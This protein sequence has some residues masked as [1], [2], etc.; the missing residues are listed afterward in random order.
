V[1]EQAAK[2][3]RSRLSSGAGSRAR[4]AL[5]CYRRDDASGFYLNAGTALELAMKARLLGYGVFAIAPSRV[6][7]GDWFAAVVRIVRDPDAAT[8]V[9]GSDALK[10]LQQ[11]EPSLHEAMQQQVQDTIARCNAVKHL[12]IGEPPG[13]DQLLSHAAAF[14]RANDVLLRVDPQKFWGEL[15]PLA[16]RLVDEELNAVGVRV[17]R[18]LLAARE[19][20]TLLGADAM[21]L[22]ADQEATAIADADDMAVSEWA[23]LNCPV[24]ESPARAFGETVDAGDAEGEFEDGAIEYRWIP[25]VVTLVKFFKCAVCGLRLAGSDELREAKVPLEVENHRV[26]PSWLAG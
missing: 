4:T 10:R 23:E 11:L 22:L 3:L 24:C 5:E 9:S 14:V 2:G 7:N 26:D 13:G 18:S 12:G 8:S 16:R 1:F 20:V 6:P 21:D 19:R 25:H 15:H 17:A